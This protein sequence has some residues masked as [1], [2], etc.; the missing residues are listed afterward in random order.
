MN[1][2]ADQPARGRVPLTESDQ[3]RVAEQFIELLV[4]APIESEHCIS[5]FVEAGEW[6]GKEYEYEGDHHLV[7][8]PLGNA[9]VNL[10]PHNKLPERKGD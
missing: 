2:K 10:G 3:K 1:S 6:N 8:D 5:A 7:I 9:W 4:P